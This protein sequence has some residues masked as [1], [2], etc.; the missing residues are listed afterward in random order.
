MKIKQITRMSDLNANKLISLHHFSIRCTRTPIFLFG[1]KLWYVCRYLKILLSKMN[2]WYRKS[3]WPTLRIFLYLRLLFHT[4][5]YFSSRN[6]HFL[7]LYH[8]KSPKCS[9]RWFSNKLK[10]AT[11]QLSWQRGVK[12]M[13]YLNNWI[14]KGS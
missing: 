5:F 11:T 13:L 14:G 8:W 10:M 7:S 4:N 1:F 9:R 12:T 3:E 2:S 6:M